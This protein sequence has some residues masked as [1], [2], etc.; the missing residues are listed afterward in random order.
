MLKKTILAAGFIALGAASAGAQWG[1]PPGYPPYGPPGYGR[2]AG[3]PPYGPPLRVFAPLP[4][5]PVWAPGAYPYARPYHGV[6]H[7]KAWR[8]REYERFAA[9]DYRISPR[10]QREI[11]ALR[12][13]LDSTCGRWRWRG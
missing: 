7:R 5:A 4:P 11:A 1:P 13:D 2:P 6:C 3:P 12:Y 10:E 8:L 9:S